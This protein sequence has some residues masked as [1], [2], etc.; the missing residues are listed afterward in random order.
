MWQWTSRSEEEDLGVLPCGRHQGLQ[1]VQPLALGLTHGDYQSFVECL[2]SARLS[3]SPVS[4]LPVYTFQAE[5]LGEPQLQLSRCTDV[6]AEEAK[7]HSRKWEGA[8]DVNFPAI[9]VSALRMPCF[10]FLNVHLFFICL[11][12]RVTE[13]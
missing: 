9:L 3:F 8:S 13:R 4:V 2:G 5:G 1:G 7:S 12:G 6:D 10:C 11:K